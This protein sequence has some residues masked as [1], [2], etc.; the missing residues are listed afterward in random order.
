MTH[1]VNTLRLPSVRLAELFDA[2]LT[3]VVALYVLAELRL[4]IVDKVID[5][6]R[7]RI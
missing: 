5:I 1:V 6:L 7:T 2:F 4:M 3:N